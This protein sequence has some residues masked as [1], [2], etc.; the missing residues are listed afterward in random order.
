MN[1]LDIYKPAFAPKSLHLVTNCLFGVLSIMQSSLYNF[2]FSI[3]KKNKTPQF[4]KQM[5]ETELKNR[6]N[7]QQTGNGTETNGEETTHIGIRDKSSNKWQEISSCS[8]E[9]KYILAFC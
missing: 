6:E 9:I 3:N 5:T 1:N 2:R 7:Y 8:P 4:N